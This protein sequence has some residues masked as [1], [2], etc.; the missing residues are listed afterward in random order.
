MRK[1]VSIFINSIKMG[2]NARLDNICLRG[3]TIVLNCLKILYQLGYI[4]GYCVF[5][6]FFVVVYLKYSSNLPIF[7]EFYGVFS[8]VKAS[9]LIRLSL[10]RREFLQGFMVIS[11]SKGVMTDLES[12]MYN[13]GGFILFYIY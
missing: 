5:N 6:S 10:D 11:S 13:I 1:V 7:R 8:R 12:I 3:S 9:S 2:S 4:R